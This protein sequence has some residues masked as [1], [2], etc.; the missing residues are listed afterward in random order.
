MRCEGDSVGVVIPELSEQD[1]LI[2]M[3]NN[4]LHLCRLMNPSQ[5]DEYT[6]LNPSV[7]K[8]LGLLVEEARTLQS[9]LLHTTSDYNHVYLYSGLFIVA[10]TLE[11]AVCILLRLVLEYPHFRTHRLVYRYVIL[12]V[13]I[14]LFFLYAHLLII[15]VFAWVYMLWFEMYYYKRAVVCLCVSPTWKQVLVLGT[16]LYPILLFSSSCVEEEHYLWYYWLTTFHFILL[17]HGMTNY[18]GLTTMSCFAILVV[19]SKLLVSLKQTGINWIDLEDMSCWLQREGNDLYYL[20]IYSYTLF[21][22][23]IMNN[24]FLVRRASTHNKLLF[25]GSVLVI[26][27]FKI[28][29]GEVTMTGQLVRYS[30]GVWLSWFI[31]LLTLIL[32]LSY[33]REFNLLFG[34][35]TGLQI[36]FLM[37]TRPYYSL[38][39]LVTLITHAILYPYILL[40]SGRGFSITT[41]ILW[42]CYAT[43]FACGNSNHFAS[44][45]LGAGF[46]GMS[47]HYEPRAT[48]Q[49]YLSVFSMFFITLSFHFAH[50]N[51]KVLWSQIHFFL[52]F[53]LYIRLLHY[54]SISL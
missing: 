49:T 23:C 39:L 19:G 25:I 35:F 26:L 9:A 33:A 40:R 48:I 37:L 36:V 24:A 6:C 41:Y 8:N 43:H 22:I 27:L 7:D 34:V 53:R 14:F 51:F 52:T 31:L 5:R 38:I 20:V 11:L 29:I 30:H 10:V 42:V 3:S 4:I 2:V 17:V 32:V 21:S 54:S 46:K 47:S 28:V 45:D 44:V 50:L 16:L 13:S 15:L 1:Q 18:T 12:S